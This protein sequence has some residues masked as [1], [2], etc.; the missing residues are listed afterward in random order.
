MLPRDEQR[1]EHIFDYCKD[2]E[3]A[4]SRFGDDFNI[5]LR[6]LWDYLR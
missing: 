6:E 1:I 3:S 5:G 4:V 2:I